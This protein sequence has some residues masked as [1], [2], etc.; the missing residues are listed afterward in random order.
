MFGSRF[1]R[2]PADPGRRRAVLGLSG[3]ALA[4][5]CGCGANRQPLRIASQVWPG[6]EFM[7]LARDEGW[8]DPGQ[9]RLIETTSATDSMHLLSAGMADGAAL[10]LDEVLRVRAGGIPLVVVAVFDFSSGADVL[11]ARPGIAKL[12][13]IRGARIGVDHSAVGALML[14]EALRVAKLTVADIHPVRLFPDE[15]EKAW[16]SG[17]IDALITYEP[18][19]TRI[20]N[21]GG[22]RL[23]DSRSLPGT[24]VDVLAINPQALQTKGEAVRALIAAH[25]RALQRFRTNPQDSAYRLAPRLKFV[26]NEVLATYKN[27]NLSSLKENW[28]LLGSASPALLDT[29]QEVSALMQSE[30]LLPVAPPLAGLID[31]AYLPAAET[32]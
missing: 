22:I 6:Y 25:F 30:K 27:L 4:G 28:R 29:A 11:L 1:S 16:R 31:P 26:A 21:L 2:R 13:D 32:Q 17:R 3:L 14:G 18:V 20:E 8:L 19:A 7:F 5:L 23:F 9:I 24:I 12:T 10:T 15:Q